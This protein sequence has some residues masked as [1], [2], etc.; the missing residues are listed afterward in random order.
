MTLDLELRW[1][2]GTAPRPATR[3]HVCSRAPP[4]INLNSTNL[5][6]TKMKLRPRIFAVRCIAHALHT[7]AISYGV[8]S[9][10]L[11]LGGFAAAH[12]VPYPHPHLYTPGS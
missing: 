10:E 6:C 8:R 12:T 4:G 9:N 3:R 2:S 11:A 7:H 1:T 5:N